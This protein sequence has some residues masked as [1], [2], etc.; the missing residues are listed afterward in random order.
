MVIIEW[1]LWESK[2]ELKEY[3]LSMKN[4]GLKCKINKISDKEWTNLRE[5]FGTFVERG[6]A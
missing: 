3:I 1:H 6:V 2:V 4:I 5:Q